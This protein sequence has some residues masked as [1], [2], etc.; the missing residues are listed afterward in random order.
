MFMN[1]NVILIWRCITTFNSLYATHFAVLSL[2]DFLSCARVNIVYMHAV[3]NLEQM[4]QNE[5]VI[6]VREYIYLQ[7]CQN[8]NQNHAV[9]VACKVC[10]DSSDFQGNAH[11]YNSMSVTVHNN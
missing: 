5:N 6:H 1:Q 3:T 10:N 9:C 7:C 11:C 8:Q 2:D 4:S